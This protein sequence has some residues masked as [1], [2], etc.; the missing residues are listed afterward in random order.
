MLEYSALDP[1]L[2]RASAK[3]AESRAL[4]LAQPPELLF[5][6]TNAS[7]MLGILDSSRL[8]ATNYR[9]LNDASEIAYGMALFESIVQER[10]ATADG[11]IVREFLGRTLDTASAFDGMFDCYIACFCERDDLLNKPHQ[12]LRR[13][14]C[15]APTWGSPREGRCIGSLDHCARI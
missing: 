7:G 14:L 4:I 2:K 1:A 5:H 8:W 12:A 13:V 10:I 3:I 9:F 15:G 6:Y 11:D